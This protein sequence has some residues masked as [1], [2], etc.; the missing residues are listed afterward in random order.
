MSAVQA[1]K[2]AR[3]A[4]IELSVDGNSLLIDAASEP[5]VS[6]IE[7]LLR[8][9]LD[10][11]GVLRSEGRLPEIPESPEA[12][13]RDR[14]EAGGCDLPQQTTGDRRTDPFA[15]AWPR[16]A[17]AALPT[18]TK[19]TGGRRSRTLTASSPP[20]R[21]GRSLGMVSARLIR[22]A[23]TAGATASVLP[24]PEPPRS[25]RFALVA[26][27]APGHRLDGYRSRHLR[28]Q[29]RHARFPQIPAHRGGGLSDTPSAVARSTF[30]RER[31]AH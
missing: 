16:S 15:S 4:G 13:R 24:P 7:E 29:R 12:D 2:A 9:K 6:V 18:L 11:V 30:A 21:E 5:P 1:I 14:R 19:P 8:H 22:P 26:S 10:I 27:S 25:D 3:A 23:C 31:P 28:A 17:G 20:W